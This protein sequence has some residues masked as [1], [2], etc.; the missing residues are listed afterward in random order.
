[1]TMDEMCQNCANQSKCTDFTKAVNFAY[2]VET[3]GI[4]CEEYQHGSLYAPAPGSG[5]EMIEMLTAVRDCIDDV[6]S[7]A[8]TA[9]TTVLHPIKPDSLRFVIDQ[10]IEFISANDVLIF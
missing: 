10:C 2:F 8:A 5:A 4:G 9:N 6:A 7:D 1:M 3:L